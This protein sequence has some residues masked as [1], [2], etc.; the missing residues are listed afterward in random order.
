MIIRKCPCGRDGVSCTPV[1]IPVCLQ[2]GGAIGQGVIKE[3]GSSMNYFQTEGKESWC[4]T[5]AASPS[6]VGSKEP[7]HYKRCTLDP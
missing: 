7:L 1:H 4:V 5:P 6:A 2:Q 3:G